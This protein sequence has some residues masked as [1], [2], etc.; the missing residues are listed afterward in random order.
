VLYKSPFGLIGRLAHPVFVGPAL[1]NTFDY[2]SKSISEL[3]LLD[4]ALRRKFK[5]SFT[6]IGQ[7]FEHMQFD[8]AEQKVDPRSE[9]ET[10][11][12]IMLTVAFHNIHNSGRSACLILVQ[13]GFAKPF[14]CRNQSV[15]RPSFRDA[16]NL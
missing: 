7:R 8:L 12:S 4:D 9:N 1:K 15:Q 10:I 16:G 6:G 13:P 5:S 3:F 11:A 14:D 2:R